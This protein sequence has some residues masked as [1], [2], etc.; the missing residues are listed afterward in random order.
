MTVFPLGIK[1]GENNKQSIAPRQSDHQQQPRS[2]RSTSQVQKVQRS[3][4]QVDKVHKQGDE[5]S[6][7]IQPLFEALNEEAGR[8]KNMAQLAGGKFDGVLTVIAHKTTP[9]RLLTEVLYTAGQAEFQKYK[10]AV[11]KGA[12]RASF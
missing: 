11:K 6:L 7:N 8:Q 3:T 9:Y 12:Q 4:G 10:F 1:T 2:T 5:D